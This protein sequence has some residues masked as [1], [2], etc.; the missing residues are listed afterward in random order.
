MK[1]TKPPRFAKKILCVLSS[2][3]KHGVMGDIEEEYRYIRKKKGR[4]AA[5]VWYISQIFLPLPFFIRTS[6]AY[7]LEMGTN[8]LKITN[9]IIMKH[10]G[11]S[12]INIFGLALG[13]A[14]CIIIMLF[15]QEELSFDRFHEKADRIYRIRQQFTFSGKV[16]D[17]IRVPSWIG[18]ALIKDYPEVEDAARLIRW[19]GK[20]STGQKRFEETLFFTDPSFLRIFSFP[21]L[22][23]DADS[24]LSGPSD[25]V[26]S[27]KLAKKYFGDQDALGRVLTVDGKS[28]FKITGILADFPKNSHIQL[29]FLGNFNHA[30]NI[31]GEERFIKDRIIAYTYILLNDP[32]SSSG[33]EE[34]F[35]SFIAGYKGEN[36]SEDRKTFLQP[37]TSIHLNSHMSSELSKNSRAFYSYALSGIALII[38]LIAC[39]NYM[40]LSTARASRR[41]LEVGIRK[42]IGAKR[43]QLVQ[44]FIGESILMTFIALVL[45]VFFAVSVLPVFNSLMERSVTIDFQRN[46]FFYIGLLGLAIVV[47]LASGCYPALYLSSFSPVGILKGERGQGRKNRLWL[48][49]GLVVFQFSLSAAF[50]IGTLSAIRQISYIEK[51]DLGFF[52][53]RV[54]ILPPP[55]KRDSSYE[56]FKADLLSDPSVTEITASTGSLGRYPGLPFSFK[57]EGISESEAVSMEYMA[58]DHN[59]FRFYGIEVIEGRDFSSFISSDKGNAIILNETAL[60][61]LG[62]ESAIGKTLEEIGGE[63]SGIVIGVV[64]D[65]HNVSIHEEIKPVVYQ[66]EPSMFGEMSVRVAP[67]KTKK[68]LSFL[69]S[70]WNEWAPESLF[71][72]RSLE[73]TLDSLYREDHKVKS[74]FMFASF[75]SIFISGLGLLGL[76]IFASEQRAKEIGIRKV[77]GASIPGIISLLCRDIG[78]SIIISNLIAWPIIYFVIRRWL[79]NFA[80]HAGIPLWIFLLGGCLTLA[81]AFFAIGFQI[82]KT[83]IAD[84]VE[85][86]KYE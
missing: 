82:L 19:A 65:F 69:E 64:W 31:F 77:L 26:I 34:K 23:G 61:K 56:A 47:G 40:N 1:E 50:I 43:S 3:K 54:Y 4:L 27:Q 68:A 13:M 70:K 41:S 9:R 85:S 38:L 73:D 81:T 71:Y 58:V 52:R 20:V 21:L 79:S 6:L 83:A 44:Q 86:L 11:F 33:L 36:Y 8:Q 84:P 49:K 74:V 72:Y 78:R 2:S 10:K 66:F 60:K 16:R 57:G 15:V 75:L 14:C 18:P 32:S 53:D 67:G 39:I 12:L 63:T 5:D 76:S 35:H 48:R 80:Y 55:I 62:W 22:K 28:D 42:V 46:L 7:S 37:L 24:V 51:M 30:R 17:S 29:D 59:F 45:A 25:V